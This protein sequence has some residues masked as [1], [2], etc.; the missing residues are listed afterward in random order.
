M[1]NRRHLSEFGGCLFFVAL[2]MQSGTTWASGYQI[3]EHSAAGLGNAFAGS[4]VVA[5]DA[6]IT[7]FNPA[8]MVELTGR[9]IQAGMSFIFPNLDYED[10]GS[11]TPASAPLSGLENGGGEVEAPIPNFYYVMDLAEDWKFGIALNVP[12]GLA[13]HYDDDWIGRYHGVESSLQTINLNP[14]FAYKI[15]DRWSVGFGLSIQRIDVTLSNAVDLGGVCAASVGSVQCSALGVVPQS[16]DGFVTVEGNDTSLGAN[17]GVMFAR[18]EKVRYGFSYRSNIKHELQGDAEFLVPANAQLLTASGA[19][20]NGNGEAKVDLPAQA[21]FGAVYH[22]TDRLTYLFSVSWTEWSRF[23][24]LRVQF[25]NPVQPDAVVTEEWDDTVRYALGVSMLRTSNV[26][27]RLGIAF[28]PT[29]IP[30][31]IRRTVRVPDGDR[32]WLS[33]GLGVRLSD[34]ARLDIGYTHLL[35]E[36]GGINNTL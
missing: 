27:L 4:E 2:A 5:D 29:P 25:D 30:N 7:F 13:T 14:N 8:G 35:I 24:E 11:Q 22:R 23:D 10:S 9:Q 17:F 21:S 3:L 19:F 20:V 33:A 32:T 26:K 28:D 15:N 31:D 36:D 18:S 34:K 6:S 16:T 12:F 1:Y